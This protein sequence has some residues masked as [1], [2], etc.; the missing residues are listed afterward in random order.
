MGDADKAVF[1]ALEDF[2]FEEMLKVII[3]HIRCSDVWFRE[4]AEGGVWKECSR[5][6]RMLW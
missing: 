4:S 3:I 2:I 1:R 6:Q 5:M